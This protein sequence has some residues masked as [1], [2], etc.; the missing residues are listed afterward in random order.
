VLFGVTCT[1]VFYYFENYTSDGIL[2][3]G[4]VFTLL[5]LETLY[6]ALSMHAIYYYVILNYLNPF[7]LLKAAWSLATALGVSRAII[8]V[9][10]LF[11]VRRVYHISKKN[12]PLVALLTALTLAH[13]GTGIVVTVQ[14]FQLQ[15]WDSFGSSEKM[16]KTW[17][18]L[19]A[20]T[21]IIIAG[22]L[23]FYLHTSRTGFGSTDT[24]IN[25]LMAYAINNGLLTSILD[26]VVL[27]FTT[28]GGSLI[29]WAIFQIIGNLYTNSM[30][31]TLNSR[32]SLAQV[33]Q[34]VL[35]KPSQA[36]DF[37]VQQS[38]ITVDTEDPRFIEA[39]K[40]LP[41]TS[42]PFGTSGSSNETGNDYRKNRG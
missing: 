16:V 26:I 30:M 23:S 10:H 24:L 40:N 1:Q 41:S 13:F 25:K 3:K 17:L 4:T 19:G 9:V 42:L 34:P 37:R 32:R 18:S 6:A 36:I 27:V 33:G 15:F 8:L 35:S 31:A 7:P 14:V 12:T 11:Y 38:V 21:D 28:S 22:S 5:I 39:P 29:F 2:I 20:T